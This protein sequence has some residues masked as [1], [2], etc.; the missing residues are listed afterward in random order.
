[1]HV[2]NAGHVRKASIGRRRNMANDQYDGN[3]NIDQ[4][5]EW[6]FEAIKSLDI[7]SY[8]TQNDAERAVIQ[9]SIT[10]SNLLKDDSLVLRI[11]S[12][13]KIYA[14]ITSMKYEESSH[15]YL[16]TFE[17]GHGDDKQKETIRTP[18]MDSHDGII[19]KPRVNTL[20]SALEK[21]DDGSVPVLLYKKNEPPR[22]NQKGPKVSSAGYRV[23]VWFDVL[24][25]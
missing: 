24:R 5:R 14:H 12:S 8:K 1:M 6:V 3:G 25:A 16:I 17:S 13:V 21:A 18:R 10:F 11:L 19:L 7:S 23:C 4:Q 15:R 20:K 9:R 2:E 22:P